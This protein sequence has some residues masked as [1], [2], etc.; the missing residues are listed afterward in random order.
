M[1]RL[2]PILILLLLSEFISSQKYVQVWGDEFN[3]P[4]LPDS[5]KWG[6]EVGKIRNAELQYYTS[7]RLENARIEDSVLIIEARKEKYSGA[8][9]TSASIISK[10]IG[11]WK[12]GKIEIS[13]KVPTGKGT[14]PALWMMP[15]YSEYGGWPRSGEI[16]V[17]EY[18]GVEPQKLHY[19]C[20]F[21]G[22]NGTGHQSS[23]TGSTFIANPFNQFIKYV[24][25]WTPDKIEW[26]ANDRKFHEYRKQPT[27]DYRSW[28]FDKEFYLIL[29]LAYGGSWGG[30]AG[31][32]DTKLPHK[33]L[34]D[35]VR[36][37]QLQDSEGPFSLTIQPSVHGKVEVSP[38][39]DL[40]PE[41]TE[42]TLTAIPDSG[43][44]FKAWA[45]QSGANPFKFAV[46]K[47]TTV[48]P[49]FYNPKELL[50]NGEFDKSWNPWS[51]YVENSQNISYTPSIV[52]ST[53]VINITKTTGTDWHL[54]FQE[55][56]LSMKKANYKLTFDAWA[57]QSKQL[58][59]TVSKN[60]TDWSAWVTKFQTISTTRKKYELTLNM[61]LNDNNVRLY[62]GVGRFLGKFYIDN[63]SLT[64]IEPVTGNHEI[65]LNENTFSIYPNPTNS[66][67]TVNFSNFSKLKEQQLELLTLD[68]KL[69]YQTK[70]LDM[71]TEINPGQIKPGIYLVK[72]WSEKTSFVKK[73]LIY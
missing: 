24:M 64:Q 49:V 71:E 48:T 1:K 34:I 45:H 56:R 25:I 68:G 35:Y 22:T 53:F 58:L 21:E 38:K 20:H 46:N 23:G 70:L 57:D 9:Y 37:Y 67:F 72:V 63:I 5:T 61:P 29:N 54:G 19:T 41:N 7:K 62:F 60:Y 6:Y 47:N 73:I 40:Y 36:V 2:L 4:G 31:V 16:D 8:D 14:W 52:D 39:L 27:F 30:Y 28:P 66:A 13:A 43:F 15:T 55:S 18:I 33:F 51:F 69:I 12:Y 42:V 44:S 10:G 17:M 11:D 3:T 50:S 59:I 65:S 26:Y 32:D